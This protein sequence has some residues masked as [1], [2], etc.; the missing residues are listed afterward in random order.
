MNRAVRPSLRQPRL[1]RVAK[2]SGPRGSPNVSGLAQ[3]GAQFSPL[4]L[5]DARV[6]RSVKL[7]DQSIWV[8]DVDVPPQGTFDHSAVDCANL[9]EPR[10]PL[11]EGLA[12][13][14]GEFHQGESGERHRTRRV[15]MQAQTWYV[16][17]GKHRADNLILLFLDEQDRES[18]YL[19]IPIRTGRHVAD[20]NPHVANPKVPWK[21]HCHAVSDFDWSVGRRLVGRTIRALVR[22][23]VT[24]PV[25]I[26]R[27]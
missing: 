24:A 21:G 19:G 2:S 6:L 20:G 1:R 8:G 26:R 27:S 9:L 3:I 23:R 16:R 14:N 4:R 7:H 18:E 10:V 12:G 22:K 13:F 15:E 11:R 25:Q 17:R 5:F